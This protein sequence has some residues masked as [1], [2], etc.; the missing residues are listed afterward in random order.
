MES[1][2]KMFR[3][4]KGAPVTWNGTQ[5]KLLESFKV[6]GPA[7]FRLVFEYAN[8]RWRQGLIIRTDRGLIHGDQTQSKSVVIWEDQGRELGFKTDP[9]TRR[10]DLNNIWDTGDGCMHSWHNGAAMI[11]EQVTPSI[12]RFRCNDGQPNDD[13]DD[14]VFR[15]EIG[16]GTVAPEARPST[17]S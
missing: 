2:E 15:L 4:S 9:K 8:Q 5:I 13:F 7:S 12:F 14:L 3:E 11:V 16:A 1:F 17:S 10:M 6:I